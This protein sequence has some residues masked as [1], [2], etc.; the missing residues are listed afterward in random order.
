MQFGASAYAAGCIVVNPD[1]AAEYDGP[2]KDGYADGYGTAKGRDSYVGE[3]R[4]GK[5]HG[6]ET[7][8]WANGS[9]HQGEQKNRGQTTV[10][11]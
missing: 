7:Y 6:H 11:S 4:N 8:T 10:F 5:Q 3:F 9:T 1:V 2:C